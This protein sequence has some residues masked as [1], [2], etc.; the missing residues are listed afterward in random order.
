MNKVKTKSHQKWS[1]IIIVSFFTLS[2][3]DIRF[4]ILGFLCMAAP[5]FHAISGRGKI[6]CSHYCPR[7]SFF[8]KFLTY[9]SLNNKLP[10]FMDT[11]AFKHFLLI[12]MIAMFSISILHADGDFN[13]IAF[14]VFRFMLASF[15]VGVIVGISYKPRSWC[16]ICPM[17]H[18]AGLI[19]K[20][21]K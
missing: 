7:G 8:G 3:L 18:A 1:W 20:V 12:L 6:H 2:I 4:G 17:G 19:S 5:M 16:K 21:I 10:K 13:K 14:S 15:I 9:I 11:K